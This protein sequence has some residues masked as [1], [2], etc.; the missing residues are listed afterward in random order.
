MVKTI[1]ISDELYEYLLEKCNKENEEFERKKA[2]WDSKYSSNKE[3]LSPE[4]Y[5]EQKKELGG[6]IKQ[7][8]LSL[9]LTKAENH[10]QG[11]KKITSNTTQPLI[12]EPLSDNIK[13][14]EPIRQITNRDISRRPPN[15]TRIRFRFRG[16]NYETQINA[17]KY[18]YST[19]NSIFKMEWNASVD[20]WKHIKDIYFKD[21]NRW[22]PLTILRG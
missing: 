9:A 8:E 19:L 12:I 18:K 6:Q 22:Q 5:E 17:L 15:D 16:Q 4:E 21:E 7:L 1:E 3:L 2:I 11:S 10:T 14:L 13:H 20:I